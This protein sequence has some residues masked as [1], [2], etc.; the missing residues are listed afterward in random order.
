MGPGYV[1]HWLLDAATPINGSSVKLYDGTTLAGGF[2]G[3][4]T[5]QTAAADNYYKFT[6]AFLSASKEVIFGS[7][8][9]EEKTL[10]RFLLNWSS[11]EYLRTHQ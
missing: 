10:R 4:N 5:A 11:L 7:K 2:P 6:T 9:K 8:K 3:F 1:P